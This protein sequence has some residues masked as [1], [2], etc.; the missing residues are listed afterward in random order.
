MDFDFSEDFD[1]PDPFSPEALRQVALRVQ[2]AIKRDKEGPL[3][4]W[5]KAPKPRSPAGAGKENPHVRSFK[6]GLFDRPARQGP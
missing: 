6:Q 1:A 4:S 2:D 3:P 5:I